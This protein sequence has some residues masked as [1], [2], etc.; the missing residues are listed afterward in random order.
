[1]SKGET[2]L[3]VERLVATNRDVEEEL[4]N[5]AR[6]ERQAEALR[7]SSPGKIDEA[8]GEAV[9]QLMADTE[10]GLLTSRESF[11][12]A[13]DITQYTPS[14]V[15]RSAPPIKQRSLDA[16]DRLTEIQAPVLA[17]KSY[18]RGIWSGV[19]LGGT[20][21]VD[22][23]VAQ[24]MGGLP[25]AHLTFDARKLLLSR[26]G[27]ST[28]ERKASMKLSLLFELGN[29]AVGA[30]SISELIGNQNIWRESYTCGHGH[31][32]NEGEVRDLIRHAEALAEATSF[33]LVIPS[34]QTK[35][36]S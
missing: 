17:A 2:G 15:T 11:E 18:M 21:R 1:M 25:D 13:I 19:S 32:T 33:E 30:E 29:T 28:F 23:S 16:F 36:I 8:I 20:P 12:A 34:L 14:R 7:K 27:D 24:G 26:D 6:L 5:A 9:S 22:I 10:A 4:A 31:R 35:S 3:L